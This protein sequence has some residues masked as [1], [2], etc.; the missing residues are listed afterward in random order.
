MCGDNCDCPNAN[1]SDMVSCFTCKQRSH[2]KCY[3]LS[4]SS[5][6]GVGG[7]NCIQ[8][9]CDSCMV[10]YS[11]QPLAISASDESPIGKAIIGTMNEMKLLLS[12][13]K[14][15]VVTTPKATTIAD[16]TAVRG[17]PAPSAILMG[18]SS[19]NRPSGPA[20][21][22]TPIPAKTVVGT[23]TSNG[24]T[25][26][27][28]RK[29]IVASH[30]SPTTTDDELQSFLKDC[31]GDDDFAPLKVT[32]MLPKDRRLEDLNFIS[33]R[34]SAPERLY[35]KLMSPDFWPIGVTIRDY[36]YRPKTQRQPATFLA[37]RQEPVPAI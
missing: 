21:E 3:G 35:S 14:G 20:M 7:T 18:R 11:N 33:F 36:A 8:F 34:I 19:S 28:S 12:E 23:L 5:A 27:E 17:L 31:L 24:L 2:L 22:A 13:M 4:K 29:T 37:Q 10:K 26:I 30:L 9:I 6:K 16:M 15:L 32:K 25:A 1:M